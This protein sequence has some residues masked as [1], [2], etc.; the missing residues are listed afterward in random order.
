MQIVQ[1]L[2]GHFSEMAHAIIWSALK[3]SMYFMWNWTF[4]FAQYCIMNVFFYIIGLVE[5]L[6]K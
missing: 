1:S 4:R 2:A 5:M 3:S 6:Q